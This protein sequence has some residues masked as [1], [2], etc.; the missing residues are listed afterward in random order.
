MRGNE[1]LP[2]WRQRERLVGNDRHTVKMGIER[3][4]DERTIARTAFDPQGLVEV[5]A[6]EPITRWLP[7]A[8][9]SPHACRN[10]VS[11]W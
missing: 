1:E 5:L 2:K 10:A 7:L 6:E 11:V 3:D 8:Q 4:H 9:T